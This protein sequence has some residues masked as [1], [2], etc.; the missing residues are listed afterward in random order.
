MP[1]VDLPEAARRLQA[2]GL[3]GVPTETVYGLAA[4]ALDPVA[5]AAIFRAKG[6]PTDH[7]LIVHVLDDP[8]VHAIAD[9]RARA[10]AAAFWPGPLTLVLP[11][12]PHVPDAV[13][14][15]HPT[16]ALRSPAHPLARALLERSGL[17]FA[18]PS[19]NRFG[20][21][22]PTTAAHVLAAFP[23]LAVLDGGRCAVGVES[24]IVD[25]TGPV[26]ALLRPGGLPVAAI[27]A[28]IGPLARSSRTA[29][30]GT[31]T[32]HYAPRA[33]LVATAAPDEEAAR[34]RALGR[35]VEVL[36]ALA[37]EAYAHALYD[38]LR[39]LDARGP[40]V[41]VAEW[42]QPGGLGDAVNDRLRRAAAT[43]NA[44]ERGPRGTT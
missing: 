32:A 25:L 16:V 34:H 11:K 3:V 28:V 5:V 13:T 15:G 33:V 7:P 23:D 20:E 44:D 14:G 29:A 12:R 42:A 9:D 27:E 4:N 24:T 40:D 26:A 2:G 43:R 31:L 38:A 41:I 19:A 1:L 30:P 36:R 39:A 8:D 37:P 6:R 10:L 21:L 18:A 22:S 17:P 35:R